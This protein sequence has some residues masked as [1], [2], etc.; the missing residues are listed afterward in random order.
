ML[1]MLPIRKG[2]APRQLT[3]AARRIKETPDATL[4]WRNIN[5]DERGATLRALL[6]EQG[7]LC[8]YCTRRVDMNTAHVEHIVPQSVAAGSDDPLSLDYGNLLAVCD[9]FEG[10]E[11]GL[12]CDRAR[13]NAPLTVN[14]LKPETLGSIRYQRDGKMLADDPV[15]RRDVAG[16][17]NLNHP[18]L[19]RNRRAALQVLFARLEREDSR[20][21]RRRVLSLCRGYVDEHLSN[22]KAREP[23]DGAIIYFMKKR[24]SAG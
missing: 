18:L 5:P 23:Y 20:G 19:I 8:A 12:T 1:A 4:S 11:E 14:P 17:L 3:D 13:G 9:G 16:T 22:P 10:S 24:L 21:G 6:D 15:I 2:V 7:S